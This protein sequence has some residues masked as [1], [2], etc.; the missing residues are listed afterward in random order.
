MSWMAK[1]SSF[2]GNQIIHYSISRDADQHG[3]DFFQAFNNLGLF[4]RLN[5]ESSVINCPK[6]L[7]D[8]ICAGLKKYQIWIQDY[9]YLFGTTQI[10]SEL[11]E[12][13]GLPRY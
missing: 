11:S 9:I 3:I 4:L 7:V 8:D 10:D 6:N 2:R 13:Y 5:N 1:F 12:G